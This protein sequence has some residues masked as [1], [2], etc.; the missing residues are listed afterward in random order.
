MAEALV[1]LVA[2]RLYRMVTDSPFEGVVE[3]CGAR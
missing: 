1:A 2:I 3:T